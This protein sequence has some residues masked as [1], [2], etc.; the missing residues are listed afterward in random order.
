MAVGYSID[1]RALRAWK[2]RNCLRHSKLELH[3]RRSGLNLVPPKAPQG[4]L[5]RRCLLN[6]LSVPCSQCPA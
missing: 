3:G 4:F 6:V 2:T 1:C 5:L